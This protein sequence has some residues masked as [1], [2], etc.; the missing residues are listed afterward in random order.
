MKYDNLSFFR[1]LYMDKLSVGWKQLYFFKFYGKFLYPMGKRFSVQVEWA[2]VILKSKLCNSKKNQETNLTWKAIWARIKHCHFFTPLLLFLVCVFLEPF[3]LFPD[4]CEAGLIILALPLRVP[5]DLTA[6]DTGLPWDTFLWALLDAF[7]FDSK[8]VGSWSLRL[9][10]LSLTGEP[11]LSKFKQ[12]KFEPRSLFWSKSRINT[13]EHFVVSHMKK[14]AIVNRY[15]SWRFILK[16]F[17]W[18]CCK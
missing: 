17:K 11:P 8:P 3:P 2:A 9:V 12:I 18:S 13:I 16:I 5:P 15:F 10:E 7:R 1:L 14:F 6:L 4:W